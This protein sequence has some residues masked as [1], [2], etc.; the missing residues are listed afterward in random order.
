MLRC[1]VVLSLTGAILGTT[2]LA[3]S[4]V[5]IGPDSN[6]CS[7]VGQPVGF[8]PSYVSQKGSGWRGYFTLYDK[9]G[10]IVTASG[11]YRVVGG[12]SVPLMEWKYVTCKDFETFQIGSGQWLMGITYFVTNELLQQR[13]GWAGGVGAEYYDT[14]LICTGGQCSTR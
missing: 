11:H 1:L 14:H 5:S 8:G 7:A 4:Q 2:S 9:N 10:Y 6:P 13:V 3:Y 12:N